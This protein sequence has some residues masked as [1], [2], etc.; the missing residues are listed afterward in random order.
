MN[1]YLKRLRRVNNFKYIEFKFKLKYGFN[2]DQM[3]N[4]TILFTNAGSL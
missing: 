2:V 1:I 3:K 4:D